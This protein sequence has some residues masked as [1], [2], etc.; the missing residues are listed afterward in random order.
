MPWASKAPSFN[1]R[2]FE[3]AS[4]R[5][6]RTLVVW[7]MTVVIT[8][9]SPSIRTL[10]TSVGRTLAAYPMS[11]SQTSPR[12]G[13]GLD[14]GHAAADTL[15][16]REAHARLL[17]QAH[18]SQ[19]HPNCSILV[20]DNSQLIINF[21]LSIFSFYLFARTTV[22]FN[23]WFFFG[24]PKIFPPK[25]CSPLLPLSCGGGFDKHQ[26]SHTSNDIMCYFSLLRRSPH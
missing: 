15:K 13:V 20:I 14:A 6:R 26:N 17:R 12:F 7:G 22:A 23:S 21:I 19:L 5:V 3:T 2:T 9:S 24:H 18:G 25:Y 11:A 4:N 8:R 16:Q 1:H 10:R